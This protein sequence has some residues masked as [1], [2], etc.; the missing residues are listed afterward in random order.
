MCK[1]NSVNVK[2]NINPFF[3]CNF[4]FI[5]KYIKNEKSIEYLKKKK[6][7]KENIMY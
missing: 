4:F 1:L 2:L 5:K 3:F 7:K 6:E